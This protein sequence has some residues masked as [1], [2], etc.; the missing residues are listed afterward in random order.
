MKRLFV[1]WVAA[2]HLG[3][4]GGAQIRHCSKVVAL[5]DAGAK[6]EATMMMMM[7]FVIVLLACIW[8]LC[9]KPPTD[10]TSCCASADGSH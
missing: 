2:S 8:R 6:G 9:V 3:A 4:T 1:I 7:V 10:Y 5:D